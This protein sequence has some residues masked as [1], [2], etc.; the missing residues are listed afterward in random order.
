MWARDSKA[1]AGST[2]T[3]GEMVTVEDMNYTEDGQYLIPDC[4]ETLAKSPATKVENKKKDGNR[5]D[6]FKHHFC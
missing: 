3:K 4:W 5:P 2:F 6:A 1:W